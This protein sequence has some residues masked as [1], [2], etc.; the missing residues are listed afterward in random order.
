MLINLHT[1]LE[2]RVRPS[3]AAALAPGAGLDAGIDWQRALELDAPS[4]LTDY[5]AKV[6]SSYPFFGS[7]AS[8]TRIAREA[9][10]DAH[11]DGQSYLELRFGPA[12]HVRDG[13]GLTDVI[14][15]VCE[16]VKQGIAITGM[17]AG[18]VVAALRLHDAETNEA[19]A[20]AAARFAGDGVVGFDLAGDEARFPDLHAFAGAFAI[21]RAAGLGLTCHAAEAAP[22]QAALDAVELLGVSRIGHGAHVADDAEVLA[23]VV[24]AGVAI[25][26]CPTS[27]LYTGA[28][29]SL[30]AHPAGRFREAGVAVVLGDDNPR[31]T[32]APLSREHAL[33]A[34]T[35]GFDAPA[36]RRLAD[37][38]IR[39]GFM[40]EH[41]RSA[42]AVRA[43]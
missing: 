36:L 23:R 22:A 19:V 10:E 16:G 37:D 26:V 13:F 42:L 41:V 35:L 24:D 14:A 12:T 1:H 30:D 15:A 34:D 8:L 39:V 3:T 38:S 43:G 9:V 21:A 40:D 5:L 18:V 20:R 29:A 17:P 33:L 31:Q 6:S 2:G 25:E 32:G 7:R 4:D 27:N 28:V 11:A